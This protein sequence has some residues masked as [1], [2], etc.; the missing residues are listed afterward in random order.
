[1]DHNKDPE[2]TSEEMTAAML[3]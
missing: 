2:P 3:R 1:M